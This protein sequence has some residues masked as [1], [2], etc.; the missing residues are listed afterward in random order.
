MGFTG[1][2]GKI[3][4]ISGLNSSEIVFWRMLIAWTTLLLFLIIKKEKLKLNNK[5]LLKFF[6]NGGLDSLTLVLFF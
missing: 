4:G 2:I 3:L 6:G 1:I 5:T